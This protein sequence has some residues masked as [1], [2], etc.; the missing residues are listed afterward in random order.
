MMPGGVTRR[1]SKRR[2]E[3]LEQRNQPLRAR[4]QD[5]ERVQKMRLHAGPKPTSSY[6]DVLP[7]LIETEVD[8][9][10]EAMRT[11]P[12]HS[13]VSIDGKDVDEKFQLARKSRLTAV[14]GNRKAS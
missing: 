14:L 7:L 3:S 9:F 11:S 4:I 10:A 13:I 12:R 5:P 6:P 8:F 1:E 2:T